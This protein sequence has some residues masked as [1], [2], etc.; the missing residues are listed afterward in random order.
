S[1]RR[2]SSETAFT[3]TTAPKRLVTSSRWTSAGS[4]MA[5][6]AAPDPAP[7]AWRRGRLD[8]QRLVDHPLEPWG[9]LPAFLCLVSDQLLGRVLGGHHCLELEH[10]GWDLHL[11]AGRTEE[12]LGH[13]AELA[14]LRVPGVQVPHGQL[15]DL[16]IEPGDGDHVAAPLHGALLGDREGDLLALAPGLLRPRAP[17]RGEPHLA[18]GHVV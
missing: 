9:L 17:V 3:A 10:L 5:R 11:A 1:P 6:P 12:A 14:L 16:R 8:L 18:A 13:P 7:P 2:T 15:G 4:G